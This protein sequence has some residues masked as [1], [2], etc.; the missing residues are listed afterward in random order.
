MG[1][2]DHSF[3]D[4]VSDFLIPFPFPRFS[5]SFETSDYVSVRFEHWLAQ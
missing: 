3:R 2:I 4:K 5:P 1:R